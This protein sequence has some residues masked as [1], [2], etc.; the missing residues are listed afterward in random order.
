ML[1]GRCANTD[2]SSP[3]F[4]RNDRVFIQPHMGGLSEVGKSRGYREAMENVRSYLE[5]GKAISPVNLKDLQ[6]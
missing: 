4:V 1:K 6:R 2:T 5:T 3:Y